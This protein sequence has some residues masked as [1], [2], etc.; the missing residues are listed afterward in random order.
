MGMRVGTQPDNVVDAQRKHVRILNP[1]QKGKDVLRHEFFRRVLD[2]YA[3]Q[4]HHERRQYGV[5][6]PCGVKTIRFIQP[7]VKFAERRRAQFYDDRFVVATE[8]VV[9]IGA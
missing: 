9:Q 3:Q 6:T 5:L 7:F 8:F 1:L 4:K 2:V